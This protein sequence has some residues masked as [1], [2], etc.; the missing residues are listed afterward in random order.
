V[1]LC[2]RTR[3]ATSLQEPARTVLA[4]GCSY[5]IAPLGIAHGALTKPAAGG[6]V[7]IELGYA[8]ST[9]ILRERHESAEPSKA[10]EASLRLTTL[11]E[12]RRTGIL[13]LSRV[14]FA[15]RNGRIGKSLGDY[16]V[17]LKGTD[18]TMPSQFSRFLALPHMA[19]F[20]VR[21]ASEH[22]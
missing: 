14:A 15:A 16:P 5:P 8:S 22:R 13:V 4:Q 6:R 10:H 20:D 11:G 9:A 21:R 3:L 2:D 1:P 19:W 18:I 7:R 17:Y 12:S